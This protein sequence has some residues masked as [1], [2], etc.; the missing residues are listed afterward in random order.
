MIYRRDMESK[1]KELGRYF[2]VILLTGARQTGKTTLMKLL[3]PDM[4]YVS[5]DLPSLA[6]KA[7]QSPEAFLQEFPPPLIIDEVQY[8]PGSKIGDRPR[9]FYETTVGTGVTEGKD[10]RKKV[11]GGR[12]G[13]GE[14]KNIAAFPPSGNIDILMPV[15]FFSSVNEGG[16]CA[17]VSRQREPFFQAGG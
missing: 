14:M 11:K 16:G 5:L 8:A 2:P 12:E 17:V 9:F 13:S 10:E 7:E 4:C 1:I 15:R 6:E 3:F